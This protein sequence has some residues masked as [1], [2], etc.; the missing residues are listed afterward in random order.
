M[1]AENQPKP[2]TLCVWWI[3]QVPGK[4]FEVEV[5]SVEEG[6]KLMRVLANYDLFQFENRIKPDFCNAGGLNVWD[7]DSDG[8]G[9]PGWVS[10]YDH[11]TG[12]DDP[13]EYLEYSQ[14]PFRESESS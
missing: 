14:R 5:A 8:E 13:E 6:V 7:A 2:G 3:P 1:K 10:W 9:N 4:A 12:I 11:E